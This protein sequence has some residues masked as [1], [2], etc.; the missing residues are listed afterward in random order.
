MGTYANWRVAADR[1]E[2]RR[3]TWVCGNQLVL[4]AEVVAT[5]RALL[6]VGELDHVVLSATQHPPAQVW[7]AAHQYPLTPGANRLVVIRDAEAITGWAPLE[8]WLNVSRNLPGV[9]L[10]LVSN[11]ADIPHQPGP[12]RRPGPA[13]AHITMLQAKRRLAQI[14][15]C[16]APGEAVAAA[17]VRRNSQLDAEMAQYLVQR[18]AA[19]LDVA[20]G[21]CTKLALFDGQPAKVVI[22]HLCPPSPPESFTD[23]LIAADKV[24]ALAALEQLTGADTLAAIALLGSRLDVLGALWRATRAG[25]SERDIQG[26]PAFLIRQYLP[27]AKHFDPRRCAYI[28]QVLAVVDDAYRSGARVGVMELLVALF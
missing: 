24:R 4:V 13:A 8:S 18:C 26:V 1:G 10:L 21:V 17:W 11:E 15:R 20:A 7:A 23:A 19:D 12:G 16:T 25:Q 27:Y 6:D 2:V 14:V 28:R 5:I 9:H 22:D 3:C